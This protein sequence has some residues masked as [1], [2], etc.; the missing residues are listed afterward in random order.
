MTMP[1][2]RSIHEPIRDDLTWDERWKGPDQ[3]FIWCWERG[4]QKRFEEP[5]LA[6]RAEMGEL[7]LL[8]WRGGVE[9]AMLPEVEES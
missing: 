9:S 8:D 1:L 5:D 3:G 7:I 6:A 4:R 2:I